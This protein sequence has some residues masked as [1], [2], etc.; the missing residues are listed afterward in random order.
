MKVL[1]LAFVEANERSVLR[2]L[3]QQLVAVQRR[4]PGAVGVVIGSNPGRVSVEGFRF[5]FIDAGQAGAERRIDRFHLAYEIIRQLKPA[6]VYLRCPLYDSHTLRLADHLKNII[7]EVQTIAEHEVAADKAALDVK[8]GPDT[9]AASR[10]IVGV[11]RQ[12][13]AYELGRSRAPVAGHVMPNGCD[14]SD[15]T[16]IPPAAP[17]PAGTVRVGVAA[18]FAP[19]HGVERVLQG[20]A[21]P[22]GERIVLDLAGH[23][24]EL[25]RYR[26]L[27]ASLG[28]ADRVQVHGHLE[29]PALRALASR[30]HVALGTLRAHVLHLTEVAALKHREYCLQGMP[31]LFAGA[32]PDFPAELPF[33]E[34]VPPTDA[35]VTPEAILRLADR[36]ARVPRLHEAARVY[37]ETRIS[38]DAK[39][40]GLVDFLRKVA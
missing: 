12:I 22:G 11:T 39:A 4:L 19:W 29:P 18:T 2:K 26:A 14:A 27:A 9:I 3:H 30:W 17:D 24:V 35:P 25:P 23:G 37:G 16:P 7:F 13:L 28:V 40:E 33:V 32:D 31:F 36:A 1:F 20:M 10:G 34:I 5:N 38:W 15:V 8:Y 6:L 21:Q